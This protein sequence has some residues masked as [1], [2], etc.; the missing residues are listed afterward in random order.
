M[1]QGSLFLNKY[2]GFSFLD[3]TVGQVYKDSWSPGSII[4]QA[5]RVPDVSEVGSTYR[6]P[7]N[8]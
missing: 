6:V 8:A 7:Q 5:G 3:V 4:V 2:L 1:D